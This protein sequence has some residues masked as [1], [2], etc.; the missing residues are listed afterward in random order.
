MLSNP[1]NRRRIHERPV[2]PV[3]G[4][5]VCGSSAYRSVE[6]EDWFDGRGEAFGEA[7]RMRVFAE[8]R[9]LR[10]LVRRQGFGR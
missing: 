4:L 10:F 2:V 8:F 7:N 6:V 3:P 5:V 9:E 1:P